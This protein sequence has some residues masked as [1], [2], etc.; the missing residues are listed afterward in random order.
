MYYIHTHGVDQVS[1]KMGVPNKLLIDLISYYSNKWDNSLIKTHQYD[2]YNNGI[3]TFG[4]FSL[5]PFK[6]YNSMYFTTD[7]SEA[8]P[9]AMLIAAAM[10]LAS[11]HIIARYFN[12]MIPPLG[13]VFWR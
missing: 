12:E 13:L 2:Y 6:L 9:Y 5:G 3:Y 11:N 7:S 8:L 4:D 1:K 10:I